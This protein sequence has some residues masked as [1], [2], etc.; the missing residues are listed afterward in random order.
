[1]NYRGRAGRRDVG[2]APCLKAMLGIAGKRGQF[3]FVTS[4]FAPL[5]TLFWRHSGILGIR[6][7]LGYSP[8]T[9]LLATEVFDGS[10]RELGIGPLKE[11]LSRSTAQPL[12]E[13][14]ESIRH[15]AIVFGKQSDDQTM[16]IIRHV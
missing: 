14:S 6:F 10:G 7:A 15:V 2:T 3:T 13:L 11:A 4:A 16:L 12:P 5:Q 8:G 1:V 9:D